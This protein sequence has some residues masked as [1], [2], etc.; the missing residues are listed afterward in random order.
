MRNRTPCVL[1]YFKKKWERIC[2]EGD[3]CGNEERMNL[4]WKGILNIFIRV[5]AHY[6]FLDTNKLM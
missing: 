2:G 3:K 5:V 6:Y 4:F 1:H